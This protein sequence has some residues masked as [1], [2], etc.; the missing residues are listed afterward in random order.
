[1]KGDVGKVFCT[2]HLHTCKVVLQVQFGPHKQKLFGA[3]SGI[4]GNCM[5]SS[6][7]LMKQWSELLYSMHTL[8]SFSSAIDHRVRLNPSEELI[9]NE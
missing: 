6:F 5:L 2:Q 9:S 1:M 3:Q 7:I 4:M 8:L